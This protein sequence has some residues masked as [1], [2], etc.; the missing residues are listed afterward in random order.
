MQTDVDAGGPFPERAGHPGVHAADQL[1][2][3]SALAQQVVAAVKSQGLSQITAASTLLID[4]PKVSRLLRGH[5]EEFSAPRLIR[6]LALLGCDVE[7]K[8]RPSLSREPRS[9][10]RLR[11]VASGTARR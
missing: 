1:T 2:A 4:Q 9:V 7:I 3:K 10:G 5:W 11:V 8:I 6:F